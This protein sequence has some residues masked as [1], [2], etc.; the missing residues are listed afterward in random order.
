MPRQIAMYLL[1]KEPQI[2]L[3]EAG[4]VLGGRDHSTIIHGSDKISAMVA[5]SET[6]RLDIAAIRKKLYAG[7]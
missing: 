2:P 1:R 4:Q 5:E 6:L 7:G 3:V